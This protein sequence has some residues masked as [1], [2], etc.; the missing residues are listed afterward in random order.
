MNSDNLSEQLIPEKI[1]KGQKMQW[2]LIKVSIYLNINI[3]LME[4]EFLVEWNLIESFLCKCD[5][6]KRKAAGKTLSQFKFKIMCLVAPW[7]KN[8]I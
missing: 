3:F 6:V 2:T 4:S 5:F 7:H 8:F 1:A